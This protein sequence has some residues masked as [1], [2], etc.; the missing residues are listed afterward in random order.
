MMNKVLT[1]LKEKDKYYLMVSMNRKT[2][3]Q[4]I[5]SITK[6]NLLQILITKMNFLML[7]NQSI[8]NNLTDRVKKVNSKMHKIFLSFPKKNKKNSKNSKNSKNNKNNKNK[9][10]KS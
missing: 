9:L 10:N 3:F 1:N 5:V 7:K 2:P 6:V 4:M 8:V